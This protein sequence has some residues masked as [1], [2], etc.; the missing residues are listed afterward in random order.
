MV[1]D[2]ETRRYGRPIQTQ[3][4][5][6]REVVVMPSSI[7]P[8]CVRGDKA[9]FAG[10]G[11]GPSRRGGGN[12]RTKEELAARPPDVVPLDVVDAK[13]PKQDDGLRV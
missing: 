4:P 5:K 7:K 2:T 6:R 13:L 11:P 9:A 8:R 10:A 3:R 12:A 1:G